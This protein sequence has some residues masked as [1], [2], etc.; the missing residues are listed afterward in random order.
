MT[1]S[2]TT[3]EA[4]SQEELSFSNFF[5][6]S[7]AF[8][9]AYFDLQYKRNISHALEDEPR[10]KKPCRRS[11]LMRIYLGYTMQTGTM[12]HEA[13]FDQGEFSSIL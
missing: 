5:N 6:R 13:V 2:A 4:T 7:T 11:K 8:D 12:S 3:M 9:S 10:K 1:S